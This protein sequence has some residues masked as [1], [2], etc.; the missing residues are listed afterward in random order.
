MSAPSIACL[1][2]VLEDVEPAVLRRV[3]VPLSI[4]LDR[5]HLAL[6]EAMGWSNSHLYEIRAGGLAWGFVDPEDYASRLDAGKALLSDALLH[7]AELAYFYDF[8]DGWE[9]TITV[10][11]LVD[12]AA[13]TLYPRLT[14]VIGRC[15]PEDVGGPG[16]YAEFRDAICNPRHEFHAQFKHWIGEDFDPNAADAAQLTKK[17]EGLAKRWSRRPGDNRTHRA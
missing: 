11:R 12:A 3:E 5:L 10:E 6:Q 13:D 17:V 8:G 4:R 16:R 14:E 15:P 7:S 2:I 9:H 1:K